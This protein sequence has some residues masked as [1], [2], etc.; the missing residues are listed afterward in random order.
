[1][2]DSG[3]LPPAAVP[4]SSTTLRTGLPRSAMTTTPTEL[5]GNRFA[6]LSSLDGARR[7]RLRSVALMTFIQSPVG[8]S[9]S[10]RHE[11]FA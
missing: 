8:T 7:R 4:A 10:E 5:K 9:L 3:R 1:M 11:A 6:Q 2:Q